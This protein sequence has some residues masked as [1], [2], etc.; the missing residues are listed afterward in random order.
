LVTESA[1]APEALLLIALGKPRPG[2]V[3]RIRANAAVS[4]AAF[5]WAAALRLAAS[6]CVQAMLAWNL[7]S[8]DAAAFARLPR[9]VRLELDAALLAARTRRFHYHAVVSPVFD[10][11]NAEGIPFALM[12]GAVVTETVYPADARWL[13]DLDVLVPVAGRSAAIST[14]VRAGF[15]VA[16][17][18]PEPD[19]CN[20]VTLTWSGA[21]AVAI[22][23]DLH[24]D[25]YPRNESFT[26]DVSGVLNRAR[27]M[28]F[29]D[30][31]VLG[32]SPADT[33]VH[34]ATQLF[35]D[36]FRVN[37]G[38][39]CDIYSLLQDASPDRVLEAAFESG[40]AGITHTALRALSLLGA[41]VPAGLLDSL[42]HRC[43]GCTV[44]SELLADH[45]WLFGNKP[46]G[47]VLMVLRPQYLPSAGHRREYWSLLP[48]SLYRRERSEHSSL[49]ASLR[50][51]RG[52]FSALAG[53]SLLQLLATT[54]RQP[55]AGSSKLRDLLWKGRNRRACLALAP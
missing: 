51:A 34:Y 22:C 6:H 26:F 7:K 23:I 37:L 12:K 11:L 18:V 25:V 8:Q 46:F 38:R 2:D 3:D 52:L 19:A 28:T 27:P 14:F 21:G 43:P 17:E 24:W 44:G 54:E 33:L 35:H 45:R 42:A 29:G 39:F 1:I 40:A 47:G 16:S 49:V 50:V 36:W 30:A 55:R 5:T 15:R 31:H 32:M 9:A 13:N 41:T 20:Q 4:D 48:R 53:G 10:R